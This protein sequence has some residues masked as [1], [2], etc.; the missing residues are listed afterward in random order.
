MEGVVYV[1][2]REATDPSRVKKLFFSVATELLAAVGGMAETSESTECSR[3]RRFFRSSRAAELLGKVPF[4]NGF[5]NDEAGTAL[6]ALLGVTKLNADVYEGVEQ[7]TVDVRVSLL[8]LSST[9][10]EGVGLSTI[11]WL[12]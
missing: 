6:L 1:E 5:L 2:I 4:G 12:S 7:G 10:R 8:R 9:P 11:G 3:V